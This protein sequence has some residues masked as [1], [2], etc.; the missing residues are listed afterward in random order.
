MINTISSYTRQ[1]VCPASSQR[2]GTINYSNMYYLC[3]IVWLLLFSYALYV[4]QKFICVVAIKNEL[5]KL[6][7]ERNQVIIVP[8]YCTS[9][10]S[11]LPNVIIFYLK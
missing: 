5:D 4:L 11:P 1:S 10:F 3:S 9:V 6:Q 2:F 8:L 7:L